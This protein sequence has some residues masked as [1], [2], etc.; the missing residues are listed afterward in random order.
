M[1]AVIGGCRRV[2]G[3]EALADGNEDRIQA[4]LPDNLPADVQKLFDA[5]FRA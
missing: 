5:G 4:M 1:S 3:G 2:G